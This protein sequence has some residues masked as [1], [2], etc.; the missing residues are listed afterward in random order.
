MGAQLPRWY[1]SNEKEESRLERDRS[2]P[3]CGSVRHL[4]HMQS[5]LSPVNREVI[6]QGK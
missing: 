6:K 1:S 4:L 3:A 5:C 2:G